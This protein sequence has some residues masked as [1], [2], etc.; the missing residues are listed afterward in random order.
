MASGKAYTYDEFVE[1]YG[2][3]APR[4]W[5]QAA[6]LPPTELLPQLRGIV[7]FS[8]PI[9][10]DHIAKKMI[11]NNISLFLGRLCPTQLA[12]A[13]LAYEVA[14]S[15]LEIPFGVISP[16][17]AL[18]SQ[19]IGAGNPSSA[20]QWLQLVLALSLALALPVSLAV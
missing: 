13:S 17:S 4:H 10:L 9:A 14:T 16:L 20:G 2:S 6:Q 7:K 15:L 12:A 1:Y 3:E 5:Q 11:S 19:A 18:T 8:A